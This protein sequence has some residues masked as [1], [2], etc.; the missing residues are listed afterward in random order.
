ME[1]VLLDEFAKQKYY[2]EM[3]S[4]MEL[5]D[6]EFVPPLSQRGST[7]QKNL[8]E[9][10]NVGSVSDYL[11]EM[12][13]QKIVAVIEDDNLLGYVSFKENYTNDIIGADTLPNIYLSTLIL[14]PASRGKGVTKKLY[15]HLFFNLY[16]N[17]NIYTRT[18]STN[19]AH[20]KILDF[21]GF[22]E[23]ARLKDDRGNGIDT[24]YFSKKQV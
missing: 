23:I 21:F 16:S 1:F 3:L 22:E 4:L 14:S 6:K 24:V 9:T 20:T 5:S 7:T 17:S 19:Y 11:N 13:N 18:W 10:E 12:T 15:S 8:K 2:D